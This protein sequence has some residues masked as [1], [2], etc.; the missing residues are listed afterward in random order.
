MR[1]EELDLAIKT[2]AL[3]L[4]R[5]IID[6]A[7]GNGSVHGEFI[8]RLIED[9]KDTISYYLD[10]NIDTI[11]EVSYFIDFLKQVARKFIKEGNSA[12]FLIYIIAWFNLKDYAK[13]NAIRDKSIYMN[14][15]LN[16]IKKEYWKAP[17]TNMAECAEETYNYLN[18][19]N[20]M[21]ANAS[22]GFTIYNSYH[23]PYILNTIMEISIDNEE[24]RWKV[25]EDK[26]SIESIVS[27]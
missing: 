19:L 21:S 12:I 11:K 5:Y 17:K 26:V 25:I 10:R 24:K 15:K 14:N 8:S 4:R 3:S 9:N 23:I 20:H 1:K 6:T 16:I 13:E 7:E 22:H 18:T 27:K 2:I